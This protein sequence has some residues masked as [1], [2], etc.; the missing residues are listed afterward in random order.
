MSATRRTLGAIR[1][2]APEGDRDHPALAPARPAYHPGMASRFVKA[3][4]RPQSLEQ[5]GEWAEGHGP[6][7]VAAA[8]W[9]AVSTWLM[10]SPEGLSNPVPVAT[11][12][13]DLCQQEDRVRLGYP[14]LTGIPFISTLSGYSTEAQQ[15]ARLVAA[16]TVADWKRAGSPHLLPSMERT[17]KY[18]H[19][20]NRQEAGLTNKET[21]A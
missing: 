12:A 19:A 6:A 1:K 16:D 7:A 21:A 13:V 4:F 2:D 9:G 18:I 14:A 17:Q 11:L 5:L 20:Y 8:R 3:E 10:W 15:E